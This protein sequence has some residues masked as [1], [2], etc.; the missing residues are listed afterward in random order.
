M[1]EEPG[2]PSESRPQTPACLLVLI[3][4]PPRA[5]KNRAGACLQEHYG[6]DHF[7]LSRTLKLLTHAH[8]DIDPAATEFHFE[9]VKDDPRAE[10]GGL[11]PRQA[12]IDYSERILKPRH[13]AGHL[14]HLSCDRLRRNSRRNCLSI[15]SGVGFLAEVTPLIMSVGTT[16]SLHLRLAHPQGLMAEDSRESL[17]LYDLGVRTMD[18]VYTGCAQLIADLER[19]GAGQMHLGQRP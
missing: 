14:G 17:D 6:G 18:L 19:A 12:Y 7:S 5:G 11:T 15:V 1:V 2:G 10:F 13:G 16:R 8:Y 9:Q 3:S 4:G